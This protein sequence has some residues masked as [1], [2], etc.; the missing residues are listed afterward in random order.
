MFINVINVIKMPA[1]DAEPYSMATPARVSPRS[2]D[3]SS[4]DLSWYDP[5]L[6]AEQ[7]INDRRFYTIRYFSFTEGGYVY[8]NHTELSLRVD[9][10]RPGTEYQF[11]VRSNNPP[12]LSQWSD[13]VT[14]TTSQIGELIL[15]CLLL[16]IMLCKYC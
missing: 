7:R 5:D 1:S 13:D 4:V 3:S 8:L 15:S 2:S 14:A 11:S 16:L 6:N 9:G 12:F 10:L